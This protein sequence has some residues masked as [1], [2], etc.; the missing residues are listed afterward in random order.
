MRVNLHQKDKFIG[1]QNTKATTAYI[2]RVL[3]EPT[4]NVKNKLTNY[5]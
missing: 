3:T 5:K 4:E 1:Y 2:V